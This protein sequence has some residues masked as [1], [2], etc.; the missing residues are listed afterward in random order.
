M[1]NGTVFYYCIFNFYPMSSITNINRSWNKSDG[2]DRNLWVKKTIGNGCLLFVHKIY[3][4][5]GASLT[6]S[7]LN[8]IEVMLVQWSVN[9]RLPISIKFSVQETEK[10]LSIKH[11]QP[12]PIRLPW[13]PSIEVPQQESPG[14]TISCSIL[15]WCGALRH[16]RP[17]TDVR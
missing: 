17:T 6:S 15:Q 3:W 12:L 14:G 4:T 16:C 1:W 2:G 13:M 9:C 8:I 5:P 7:M 11:M 10:L